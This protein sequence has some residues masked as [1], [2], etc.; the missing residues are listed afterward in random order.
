MFH[1][2]VQQHMQC[3]VAFLTSFN[4]K[5]AKESSSEKKFKSV[6]SWQNYGHECVAHFLA[7][8]VRQLSPNSLDKTSGIKRSSDLSKNDANNYKSTIAILHS[9]PVNNHEYAKYQINFFHLCCATTYDGKI[10][11]YIIQHTVKF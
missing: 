11:L 8:P 1:K 4:Y 10:K 6:Q 3:V 9:S 5:F 2:V 7:H